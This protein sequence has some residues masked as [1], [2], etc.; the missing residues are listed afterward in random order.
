MG[1]IKNAEF[2][3]SAKYNQAGFIQYYNRLMAL[4]MSMFEWKNMPKQ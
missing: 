4:S 1:R 2:W 3:Q